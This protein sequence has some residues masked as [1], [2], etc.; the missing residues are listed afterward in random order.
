VLDIERLNSG[1]PISLR[2]HCHITMD[3]LD[4]FCPSPLSS[5]CER[6]VVKS[7]LAELNMMDGKH[8]S[9]EGPPRQRRRSMRWTQHKGPLRFAKRQADAEASYDRGEENILKLGNTIRLWLS[10]CANGC[11][12]FSGAGLEPFFNAFP[13]QRHAVSETP[14]ILAAA[15]RSTQGIEVLQVRS[16]HPLPPDTLFMIAA[17]Q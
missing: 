15:L 14:G 11:A 1:Q 2:F 8:F 17:T 6:P 3:Q 7:L 10:S 5:I 13:R 12:S 16:E 4:G 9:P